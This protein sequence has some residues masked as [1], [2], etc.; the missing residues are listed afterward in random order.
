[1]AGGA[2]RIKI[3]DGT[4]PVIAFA[5]AQ[6]A[7]ECKMAFGLDNVTIEKLSE[8]GGQKTPMIPLPDKALVFA[9]FARLQEM[10]SDPVAFPYSEYLVQIKNNA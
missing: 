5:T 1:M 7:G 8:Y 2:A 3:G 4:S 9:S 10:Q 6:A